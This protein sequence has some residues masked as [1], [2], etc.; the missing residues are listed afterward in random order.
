[1]ILI[2][3]SGSTKT[4]WRVSGDHV[5]SENTCITKGIN[6]FHQTTE[7]ILMSLKESFSLAVDE[8]NEIY[9]YGA[10][11]ANQ[12]K[13]NIVRSA[14]FS[15][16]G[17][18]KIY[19][20]SDL[21]GAARSLCG[22]SAGIACILGTGSNSC[23]YDGKNVIDNVSPLGYILGD[24]GSGAYLG[25]QLI[26]DILKKQLP[27]NLIDLFWQEHQ[28]NRAEI[29]EHVYKKP[30]ANRYLAQYTKFLSKHI[31]QA[32]LDRLVTQSFSSFVQRNLLQYNNV[33]HLE[34]NFTGSVAYYFR[35][36][37][38]KALNQHNLTL[39]I[40][41]QAPMSGLEKYHRLTK[42]HHDR[43]N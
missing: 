22:N 11:C 39:G 43:H 40:V 4:E 6:P 1:M 10:G 7:E 15:F 28:T 13:N 19:V 27:D 2:A 18:D 32:A 21:A 14:L 30:M 3:D 9:F 33:L 24:E 41:T 42:L 12:E 38:K 16:F 23:L 17:T 5:G 26:G 31:H 25:K 29:L 35:P 37:L 8:I 20:D 34:V 36:Q